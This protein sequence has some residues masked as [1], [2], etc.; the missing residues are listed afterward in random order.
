MFE[1]SNIENNDYQQFNYQQFNYQQ[2]NDQ[3]LNDQQLN[4]QQF[5]YQQLNDQQLNDQ[6]LNDN[7]QKDENDECLPIKI[8]SEKE[9]IINVFLYK[10]VEI[11]API[12]HSLGFSPNSI[13]TLSLIPAFISYY[14][15]IKKDIRCLIYYIIYMIL[16]YTDGYVARKYKLY[17]DFGDKYDHARDILFHL[18]LLSVFYKNIKILIIFILFNILGFSLFG[19]QEIL[20][21]NKCK[22][23]TNKSIMWLKPLCTQNVFLDI[24]NYFIGTSSM[25]VGTIIAMYL[26]C[27]IK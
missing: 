8:G 4:D 9:S 19:C 14:Y 13:T 11:I 18:L 21:E 12:F 5:N 7:K 20:Y 24:F 22:N 3:Q 6:Q 25:Y 27:N 26:Y 23:A 17:S 10:I 2:L 15:F 16:D 1:L